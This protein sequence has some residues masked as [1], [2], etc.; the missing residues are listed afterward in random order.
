MLSDDAIPVRVAYRMV[1]CQKYFSLDVKATTGQV[2][3]PACQVD[4]PSN[5]V[6]VMCAALL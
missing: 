1:A 3:G 5:S 6:E 4:D 2:D